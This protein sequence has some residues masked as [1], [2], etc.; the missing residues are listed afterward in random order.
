MTYEEYQAFKTFEWCLKFWFGD[1]QKG[2][3]DEQTTSEEEK[4]EE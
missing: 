4:K 3:K 2:E 1:K